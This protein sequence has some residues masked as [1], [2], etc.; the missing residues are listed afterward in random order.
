MWSRLAVRRTRRFSSIKQLASI[1]LSEEQR[2]FQQLAREFSQKELAPYASKWDEDKLFPVETLR[3]A[4]ELGFAGVYVSSEYGGTGLGRKDAAVIFEQLSMGCVGSTAYLTIHNMCSWILDSFGNEEQKAKYLIQLT[5]LDLFSSYC[6]TEPGSGSDAASLSTTAK[7]VGNSYVLNGS[8]AFISGG[9][10]SDVYF[11]MARTS[12]DPGPNGIS[13]FLV[14]KGFKGL[15]FGA[16]EK[17]MGWNCQPTAMV[18]MEDCEVPAANMIGKPGDGFKI[19]MK[20]LDGGRINIGVCSVG[21]AQACLEAAVDHVKVRKQF[22]KTL[23]SFQ[24]L[25]FK[26]ADMA[27]EINL[28]RLS[29]F[30]AAE[31]LDNKDPLANTA[32]A[33]AK[34]V[35]TDMGFKV[36][37]EAMQLFGGYGYLKDYPVERFCRDVRVHQILE[38]TNEIMRLVISRNILK[39]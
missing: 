23:D 39:E 31:L 4:A 20:A 22:G 8:K 3:K 27:T 2:E 26:I 34:R 16:N 30:Q 35:A 18:I 13:C 6:L 9:G 36:C 37:N 10:V 25:R 12:E 33:M 28:A 38:G 5:S 21:A 32:A 29:I 17:K 15:S 19:A 24:H 11:V 7:R 14:E 1:G